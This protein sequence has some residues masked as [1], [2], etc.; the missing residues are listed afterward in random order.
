MYVSPETVCYTFRSN[1]LRDMHRKIG[2]AD[3]GPA[4]RCESPSCGVAK[5]DQSRCNR[6]KD[7][8]RRCRATH[9]PIDKLT[10]QVDWC[11]DAMY[12]LARG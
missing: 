10:A 9:R 5:E 2:S 11:I 3:I 12:A 1:Q 8:Q 7:A 4:P 6:L